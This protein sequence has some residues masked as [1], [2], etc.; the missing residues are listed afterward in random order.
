MTVGNIWRCRAH[1][2]GNPAKNWD[3]GHLV[4]G[5]GR[6]TID[7]EISEAYKDVSGV[8]DVV[9]GAGISKK[10]AKLKPL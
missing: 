1:L 8:V 2:P 9:Y 3:R 7:E 6:S 10:V 5:A 4:R